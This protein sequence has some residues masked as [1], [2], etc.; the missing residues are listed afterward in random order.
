M[1]RRSARLGTH[2]PCSQRR[3]CV[4]CACRVRGAPALA[5]SGVQVQPFDQIDDPVKLRR[6]VQAILILDAELQPARSCCAA[7]SRRRA[8]WSTRSTARWA[9]CP[10]TARRSTNSSRSGST[11]SRSTPSARARPAAASS[12]TL[13]AD[14]K[15][16]RLANLSDSP[17]SFGT[18]E[19]H[20]EMTSFLGVPVRVHGEVYGNLYLTNKRHAKEFSADDEELVLALAMAA[21]IAI[22][23]ARLHSLVRDH[24]LTEDRDRIARD[25]H[26]SVIQRLF[27]IGLSLQGT[28]RLVERPEAVLAH[29]RGDRQ[30]RRDD[31]AVAQG[32]LRHRADDQ[33]GRPPTQG[34]RS[35]PRAAARSQSPSAGFDHRPGRPCRHR[36]AG[37]GGARRPARGAHQRG[38]ARSGDEG[39]RHGHR[40]RRVAGRRGGRRRRR[41]RG[42]RSARAPW[43]SRTCA[44]GRSASTA[45]WRSAPR[46]RVAPAS[47]GT[48]PC[49]PST[50]PSRPRRARAPTATTSGSPPARDPANIEDGPLPGARGSP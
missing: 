21:G 42:R 38:Q 34:A 7:S 4:P 33:Q 50:R 13:I 28:A 26:D 10:P 1:P 46:G 37:R 17:D 40:G 24:A 39:G 14:D 30:A 29:R 25:L 43:A 16:L 18:P 27:A 8:T 31:P 2:R 15:P 44:T 32:D 19:Y 12:G 45:A 49:R 36:A 5:W 11:A 35:R 41:R 47:P 48:C 6:L 22:E 23:N 20:P 9:C 3:L